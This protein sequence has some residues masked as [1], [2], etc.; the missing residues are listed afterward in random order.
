[1]SAMQ[2][3]EEL[4]GLSRS[5][6]VLR[7]QLSKFGDGGNDFSG[8]PKAAEALVSSGLVGHQPEERRKRHGS[9]TGTGAEEL[10]NGLDMAA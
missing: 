2:R 5:F 8:Y 10:Q 4:A 7:L 6:A 9:A 1:M 3:A